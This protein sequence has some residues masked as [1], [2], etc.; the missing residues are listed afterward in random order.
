[1]IPLIGKEGKV[2]EAGVRVY[3][4]AHTDKMTVETFVP[5]CSMSQAQLS[6]HGHRDA[7]KFFVSV[8]GNT[9]FAFLLIFLLIKFKRLHAMNY[10]SLCNYSL[11]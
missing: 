10:A 3:A 11:V 2:D 4:D 9:H 8:P 6:F 7:V 1:M 5:Y